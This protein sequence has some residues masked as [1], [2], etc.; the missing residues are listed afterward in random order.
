MVQDLLGL[1]GV[2]ARLDGLAEGLVD[3]LYSV[4]QA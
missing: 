4:F 2:Q 1:L 3:K